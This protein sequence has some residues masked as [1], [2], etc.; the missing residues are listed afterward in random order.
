VAHSKTWR[1]S[2]L[3]WVAP[4][5]ALVLVAAA[6]GGGG[7][8]SS[9]GGGGNQANATSGDGITGLVQD[10]AKP[11]PGGSATY[12]L[13]AETAGGWCLPEAELAPEGIQ[14]A[15]AI[16]DYLAVPN[17]K[18]DYVPYLADK[19][20]PN[21]E[22]TVWTIHL[23]SG[24]KFH[25][26]TALDAQVVKDNLDAYRGKHPPR[27]PLL[28]IF[29]LNQISDVK[30]VDPMTVEVDTTQPWV[31][32]PAHLYSYGR[33]GIMAEK[34]LNDGDNCF[35][36]MIGTGPF[37]FDGDWV[38]N[39]H[40]TVV[41]NDNYWRKDKDGQRLPYL[42]KI[43]FKPIVETATFVN[44]METGQ[45][46]LGQSDSTTAIYT[47]RQDVKSGNLSMLEV[48]RNQEVFYSI[49]NASK[50]P[51]DNI[52]ARQ[53]FG[54]AINADEYNKVANKGLLT[55]AFGP[56]G[57]G[58][59]GY[60]RESQYPAGTI[61][62]YNPT[63][64]KQ[65]AQQ[66]EQQTGQALAFSYIAPTDPISLRNAQLIQN[67][68]KAVGI[69]MNIQQEE[70]SRTIDDVINGNYQVAGWRNHPGFD[71]DAQWVWWH[72]DAAAANTN[73]ATNVA[74][75]PAPATGNN[76]DNPVNF[77]RFNDQVINQSLETGRTNPD[78]AVRKKAYEDLN[79]EFAKQSWEAW[80]YYAL[81]TIPA[82]TNVRGVLGP[83]LPTANDPNA[84]G[85]SPFLGF[86][87]YDVSGL[88]LKK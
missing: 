52:L 20:T 8:N 78:P 30:V 39:D 7:D 31:A 81:W 44:G 17:E 19:I 2:A 25:D 76:C 63:K 35:K 16:Y 18:G 48:S 5:L 85:D 1:S 32:F 21:A 47:L 72:C 36:D 64:A 15:R 77:S 79:K 61:I 56:F 84:T 23:R 24:I 58:T 69:R 38:P 60:L 42:D 6:C 66:Y 29:E 80:G 55:Q 87:G 34:Q 12:A 45:F 51:F 49:F 74:N 40:L 41:K 3:R 27:K 9:G 82:Q 70:Q 59:D 10:S 13:G 22:Y 88:W 57:P 75:P 86:Y 71:P 68:M 11:T 73:G 28:F 46:T 4:A 50:P 53:A 43:T 67:Y 83:D 14:V 62:K 26:G 37:K 33:L 65:L 54:Y